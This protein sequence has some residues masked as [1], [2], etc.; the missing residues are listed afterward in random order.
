MKLTLYKCTCEEQVTFSLLLL[1]QVIKIVAFNYRNFFLVNCI[2]ENAY[3]LSLTKFFLDLF[4]YFAE[5]YFSI[6][7]TIPGVTKMLP[8]INQAISFKYYI[9]KVGIGKKSRNKNQDII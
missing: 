5:K 2:L 6:Y 4:L 3:R 7:M 1:I 9:G 8:I